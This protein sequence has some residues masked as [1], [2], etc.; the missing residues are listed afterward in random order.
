[1]GKQLRIEKTIF[2]VCVV[3]ISWIIVFMWLGRT[4]KG[5]GNVDFWAIMLIGSAVITFFAFL[6]LPGNVDE[7]G[8]FRESRIR[9]AVTATLIITY[10]VYFGSVVYLSPEVDEGGKIVN[11]FAQ[12]LLPTL[13]NL[14]M[15]TISFYFGSTAAIEIAGSLSKR[16]G[17]KE[18]G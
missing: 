1:M 14:L 12:D 3:V 11:T 13:T 9:L 10:L 4:Y 8:A 16:R 5:Q 2:V 15:V 17:S 7:N 6:G 18:E